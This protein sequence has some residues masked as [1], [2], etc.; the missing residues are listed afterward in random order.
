MQVSLATY[1]NKRS[2][3]APYA[4]L[5]A[6]SLLLHHAFD[7]FSVESVRGE[8]VLPSNEA[9]LAANLVLGFSLDG[10]RPRCFPRGGSV[11]DLMQYSITRKEFDVLVS[12]RG[13]CLWPG[14]EKMKNRYR[15][16][17]KR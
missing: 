12:E 1:I 2:K 3:H 13:G 11:V 9:W 8:V 14:T 17:R 15:F 5:E 7:A 16:C 4:S 6:R 10:R